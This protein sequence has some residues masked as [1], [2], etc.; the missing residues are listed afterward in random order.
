M[1]D[2]AQALRV[3]TFPP[4]VQKLVSADTITQSH[5]EAL[6]R[7]ADS[8]MLL[9]EAIAKV[10]GKHLSSDQTESLVQEM[11]ERL[12]LHKDIGDYVT[13]DD[14]ILALDYL[15]GD[16][17]SEHKVCPLCGFLELYYKK[18]DGKNERL[19]CKRCSWTEEPSDKLWELK[20]RIRTLRL[21]QLGLKPYWEEV[22][23]S[24]LCR[25][26]QS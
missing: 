17:L 14:F 23:L 15:L 11:L 13:S 3:L 21:K 12:N 24:D 18:I 10:L 16:V 22:P 26:T 8:P 5:A 20:H 6:A 1:L 7:I 2:V 4:E 25:T 19:A 9:S